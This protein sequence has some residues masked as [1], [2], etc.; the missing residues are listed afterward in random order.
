MKWIV[1]TLS[2]LILLG[3]EAWFLWPRETWKFEWEPLLTF[4]AALSAFIAIERKYLMQQK[5]NAAVADIELAK[6]IIEPFNNRGTLAFFEHQDFG[7]AFHKCDISPLIE[8]LNNSLDLERKFINK[9]AEKSRKE[10]YSKAEILRGLLSKHTFY[11]K[12]CDSTL[13]VY[14]ELDPNNSIRKNAVFSI[15]KAADEFSTAYEVFYQTA[16]SEFGNEYV[17]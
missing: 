6:L 14:L 7:S 9:K 17:L 13:K 2:L 11:I 16:R 8:I 12:D 1:W 4:F 15:N 5:N 3:A 10:M